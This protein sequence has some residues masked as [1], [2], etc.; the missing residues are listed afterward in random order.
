MFENKSHEKLCHK[1]SS[2]KCQVSHCRCIAPNHITRYPFV[3]TVPFG[4]RAR[5]IQLHVCV[6]TYIEPESCTLSNGTGSW[7]RLVTAIKWQCLPALVRFMTRR[8]WVGSL[9]KFLFAAISMFKPGNIHLLARGK[10]YLSN[11]KPPSRVSYGQLSLLIEQS[12]PCRSFEHIYVIKRLNSE[13]PLISTRPPLRPSLN[14]IHK[15]I[16]IR[17]TPTNWIMWYRYASR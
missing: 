9:L 10:L 11:K 7:T 3:A 4:H 17:S 16:G 8:F 14:V 15:G 6:L 5:N 1:L 2:V 13:F 12:M